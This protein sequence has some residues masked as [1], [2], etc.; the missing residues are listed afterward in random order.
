[1]TVDVQGGEP[2]SRVQLSLTVDDLDA[3]VSFYSTL[4][5]VA[6]AKHRDGYANFALDDPPL[7][8]CLM[9]GYGAP[10]TVN[11]LG[12]EVGGAQ[13]VDGAFDRLTAAGIPV[14]GH[15]E[16]HC[17]YARQAKVWLD[18]PDGQ[19]WEVYTVVEDTEAACE[20]GYSVDP[21]TV[22]ASRRPVRRLRRL[23]GR[24]RRRVSSR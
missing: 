24:A 23:A 9:T 13:A 11:H 5:G 3:A 21:R 22:R 1:V 6:P 14:I 2:R 17:C 15:R 12:I 4:L 18:D 20:A 8:L 16:V 10:G 7:K 19:R